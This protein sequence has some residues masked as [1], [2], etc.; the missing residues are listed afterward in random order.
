MYTIKELKKVNTA[1][2]PT[3]EKNIKALCPMVIVK[4]SPDP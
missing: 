3:P 4:S 1:P 2:I